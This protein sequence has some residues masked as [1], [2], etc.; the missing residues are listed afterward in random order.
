MKVYYYDDPVVITLEIDDPNFTRVVR[1]FENN[2]LK[3]VVK[4]NLIDCEV[5]LD[6]SKMNFFDKLV[7]FYVS[8]QL[9]LAHQLQMALKTLDIDLEKS[10]VPKIRGEIL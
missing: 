2:K 1:E 7:A 8:D 10:I 5:H 9:F 4:D 3:V 6:K